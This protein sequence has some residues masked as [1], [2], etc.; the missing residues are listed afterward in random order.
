M[1][2]RERRKTKG[3]SERKKGKKGKDRWWKNEERKGERKWSL[4]KI[5]ENIWSKIERQTIYKSETERM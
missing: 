3:N 4:I 2:V 1:K 5:T